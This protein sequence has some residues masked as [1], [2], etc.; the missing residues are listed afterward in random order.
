ML[1]RDPRASLVVALS[2]AA[3]LGVLAA[4]AAEV[5]RAYPG[6]FF[7]ADYRIFP[8]DAASRAAGLAYGDRIV[9]VDGRSPTALV[10]TLAATRGPVEY[11]VARGDRQF[12]V[13]LEPLPVTWALLFHHFTAYFLV[14][15]IML[16]TGVVVFAQNPSAAPNRY[17]LVYMCLWAVSNVAVPE[18]VL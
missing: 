13:A 7:S 9:A 2:V 6:F 15:A 12:R 1:R 3:I 16:A 11:A 18:A 8:V 5:G 14:S 17:F 10:A 4:L